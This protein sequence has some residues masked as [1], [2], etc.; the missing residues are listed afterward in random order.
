VYFGP[1]PPAGQDSNWVPTQSGGEFEVMFRAYAPTK[2]FFDKTWKLSD[3]E[4]VN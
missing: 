2:L 4:K 1:Q 3:I